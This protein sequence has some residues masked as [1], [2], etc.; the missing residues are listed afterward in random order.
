LQQRP[1]W[2]EEPLGE[3]LDILLPEFDQ[4][5]LSFIHSSSGWT[6]GFYSGAMDAYQ[7]KVR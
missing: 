3:S 6:R 4:T 7:A 5:G 2:L 1:S